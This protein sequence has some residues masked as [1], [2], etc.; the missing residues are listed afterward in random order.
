MKLPQIDDTDDPYYNLITAMFRDLML[1]LRGE[2]YVEIPPAQKHNRRE[3]ATM[4]RE[5]LRLE[6]QAYINHPD[7]E[8]WAIRIHM[9]PDDLRQRFINASS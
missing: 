2:G 9:N 3:V 8:D 5:E 7:F 1:D 4:I 6:A